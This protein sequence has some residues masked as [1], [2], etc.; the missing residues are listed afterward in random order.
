MLNNNLV[1]GGC[2]L[3]TNM[4]DCI[5]TY[6]VEKNPVSPVYKTSLKSDDKHQ[7]S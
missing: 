6:E 1:A 3:D 2:S 7:G 5:E 4:V